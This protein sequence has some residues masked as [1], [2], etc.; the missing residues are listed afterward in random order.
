MFLLLAC[1]R[2]EPPDPMSEV[3]L[4]QIRADVERIAGDA[5]GGRVPGTPG[6]DE[7]RDFLAAEMEAAGLVPALGADGFV[8]PITLQ[9][10]RERHGLDADGAVFEVPPDPP[11]ANLFGVLP[12][13][14]EELILL[15]AHYDHLGVEADGDVYNGAF[16]DATAVAALLE[17]ARAHVR[18]GAELPRSVGFLF[19]DSEEDGLQGAAAWL[20]APSVEDVVAALSV[21]PIGRPL[22]PDYG[23]LFTIGSERSPQIRAALD[24]AGAPFRQ[25]TRAGVFGFASD[26]D[27]FWAAPEPVPA[28]WITSGGMTFYHQT[29]D[30]PETIDYASVRDHLAAIDRL[31]GALA[32]GERPEDIGPQPLSVADLAEAVAT[33]D[34]ALGSA[35]LTDEERAIGQD[36]LDDLADGVAAGDAS[37]PELLTT[38]VAVLAYVITQLAPAH[39]G[40][41]PPPFPGE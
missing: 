41:I 29:T 19:T 14:S 11:G 8:L 27:V 5:T 36:F 35:E 7:V 39:P 25:L 13:A 1:A 18:A 34:G 28:L 16:D 32:A 24:A 2:P 9:T 6:H 3:S 12:G 21:D 17:L 31:V 20:A 33:I 37:D 10:T 40:P 26:Q 4:S 15:V 30:D 38:Y 23:P 22:L